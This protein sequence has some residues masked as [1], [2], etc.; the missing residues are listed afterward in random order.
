MQ[1]IRGNPQIDCPFAIGEIIELRKYPH[2][3]DV[4][5]FERNNLTGIW[6]EAYL[7]KYPHLFQ[8]MNWWERRDISE[9]PEYVEKHGDIYKAFHYPKDN[10]GRLLIEIVSNDFEGFE[11]LQ[12]DNFLPAT[13][14]EYLEY[15][16]GKI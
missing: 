7:K 11:T 12:I 15:K 9:M 4:W 13:H 6:D 14:E 10:N 1:I 16:K 3:G 2:N 8:K 5:G